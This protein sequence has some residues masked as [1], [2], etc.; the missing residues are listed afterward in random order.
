MSIIVYIL[1]F[2]FDLFL[3]EKFQEENRHIKFLFHEITG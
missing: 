3:H 1:H 2:Q